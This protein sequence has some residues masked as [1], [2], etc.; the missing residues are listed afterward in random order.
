MWFKLVFSKIK[1][2]SSKFV[3]NKILYYFMILTSA[4]TLAN[5][6]F[7]GFN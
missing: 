7:N 4:H 3:D 5:K 6:M 1:T 2:P